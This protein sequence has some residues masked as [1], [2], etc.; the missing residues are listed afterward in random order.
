MAI[1]LAAILLSAVVIVPTL[2]GLFLSGRGIELRVLGAVMVLP[3][4]GVWVWIGSSLIFDFTIGRGDG[5]TELS[6]F[7]MCL[8]LGAV[9]AIL[10]GIGRAQAER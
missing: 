1:I 10:G 8:A 3:L 5:W 2:A 7:V 4:L 9:G 6:Y